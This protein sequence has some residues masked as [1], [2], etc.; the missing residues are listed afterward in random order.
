MNHSN[1]F[2]EEGR[3]QWEK[4]LSLLKRN[5]GKVHFLTASGQHIVG[6]KKIIQYGDVRFKDYLKNLIVDSTIFG[7]MKLTKG[8]KVSFSS[9]KEIYTKTKR[10]K[11]FEDSFF[12]TDNTLLHLYREGLYKAIWDGRLPEYL[13]VSDISM[14]DYRTFQNEHGYHLMKGKIK[15][16]VL[17]KSFIK[18]LKSWDNRKTKITIPFEAYVDIDKY[19]GIDNPF[20]LNIHALEVPV[21]FKPRADSLKK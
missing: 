4:Q 5:L 1:T 2:R 15:V 11:L 20:G 7:S 6:E 3:I 18:E 21:V 16:T 12:K 9:G 17:V 10:L 8:F 13:E 14:E 19:G